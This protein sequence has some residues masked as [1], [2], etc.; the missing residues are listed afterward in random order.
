MITSLPQ[1]VTCPYHCSLSGKSGA[2]QRFCRRADENDRCR[3]L[4]GYHQNRLLLRYGMAADLSD[5]YRKYFDT[6]I[7][8][9]CFPPGNP[10]G[11]KR[12]T[13]D[14]LYELFDSARIYRDSFI[15]TASGPLKSSY[16]ITIDIATNP[17]KLPPWLRFLP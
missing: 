8:L 17:V 3:R 2:G 12:Q 5:E 16:A 15:N 7:F 9:H 6:F 4:Q 1:S 13:R 10:T 14:D 11:T